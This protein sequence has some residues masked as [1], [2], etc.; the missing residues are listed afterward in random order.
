MPRS[1]STPDPNGPSP[2]T[3]W[4]LL[5]RSVLGVLI[6]MVLLAIGRLWLPFEIQVPEAL[7]AHQAIDPAQ[8]L[9]FEVL[10]LGARFSRAEL[11][12]QSGQKIAAVGPQRRI[13]LKGMLGFGQQYRLHLDAE[14]PWL[15]QSTQTDVDIV[16][17]PLPKIL[18]SMKPQLDAEGEFEL[19]FQGRVGHLSSDGALA[20]TVK[21]A[22]DQ[23]QFRLTA[24]HPDRAQGQHLPVTVHWTTPEGIPLPSFEIEVGTAPAL[25]VALEIE[26][27]K[28]LG[29]AMPAELSFSEPILRRDQALEGME[30]VDS[31]GRRLPGKWLWYGKQKVQFRPDPQ[32]PAEETIEIRVRPGSPRSVQGGTLA[33]PWSGRFSTGLDRRIEVFL[34]R[35]RVEVFENNTLI[36]TLRASTGK[37]KTP[38]V[39]G[40]FYIYARYPKKTMKSTGLRPGEKGYYEVKDVPYA[41]YFYEGYA[42]HG[43]FWHNAF[44]QPAS[45]GCINLATQQKNSR[46][47]INEDAGWLY[48]WASLGVPV[49]VHER[50]EKRAE[51]LAAPLR[52]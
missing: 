43:A 31:Q 7:S 4:R 33:R 27:Q 14:R 24:V 40:S 10:G 45:H 26:G 20:F 21:A 41:Q 15:G 30:V 18:S 23:Q 32:W 37:S 6:P 22:E 13:V 12:D 34:D 47:G 2:R 52:P 11:F 19:R 25:T 48:D 50:A 9:S 17:P 39:T 46:K 51:D 1:A 29:L 49:I 28:N 8:P 3:R 5:G 38:T 44:G 16:T 35:Q 42:F 36:K